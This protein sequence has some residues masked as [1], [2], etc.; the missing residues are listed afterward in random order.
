MNLKNIKKQDE[1]FMLQLLKNSKKHMLLTRIWNKEG[2]YRNLYEY[3]D[4]YLLHVKF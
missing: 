2:V 4:E 3:R 1:I